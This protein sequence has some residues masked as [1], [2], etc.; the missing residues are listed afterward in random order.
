MP[1]NPSLIAKSIQLQVP[2]FNKNFKKYLTQKKIK[3]KK[4]TKP[5]TRYSEFNLS[6]LQSL[7]G[8]MIPT[9]D[10]LQK[11]IPSCLA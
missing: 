3:K 6:W 2:A 9:E 8:K 1:L 7:Q 4:K 11:W 5:L 10:L